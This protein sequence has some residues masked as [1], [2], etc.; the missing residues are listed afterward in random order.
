LLG[1]FFTQFL[2]KNELLF[3]NACFFGAKNV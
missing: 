3:A 2:K 1:A